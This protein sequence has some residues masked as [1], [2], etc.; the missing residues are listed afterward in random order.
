MKSLKRIFNEHKRISEVMYGKNHSTSSRVYRFPAFIESQSHG[1]AE[2]SKES[3]IT[4]N[5]YLLE[6]AFPEVI[7]RLR[8]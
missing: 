8:K 3:H 7:G 6:H 1:Q 2:A 4:G 5:S